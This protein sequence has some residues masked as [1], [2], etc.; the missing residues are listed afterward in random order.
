MARKR[1]T[2]RPN[3]ASGIFGT[4][5][6]G[7]FVL[8]GLFV[9]IPTF[10]AFGVLWTLAAVA[11]TGMNAYHAFGKKYI[12]PEIYIEDDTEK[13]AGSGSSVE[14]RLQELR[15]IYDRRLITDEEYEAKRKEI[16]DEL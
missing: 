14:E 3:K 9:A 4:I 1:I 13:P 15:E 8:M 16:L 5:W 12:G 2:H 11:I 10:G 6:G 7:L